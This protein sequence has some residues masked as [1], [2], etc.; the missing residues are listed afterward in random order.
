MKETIITIMLLV[1]IALLSYG[2]GQI[3]KQTSNQSLE[4]TETETK[5]PEEMIGDK[6]IFDC[7]YITSRS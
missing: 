6:K 7:L 4:N 2:C 1:G 5:T 3:N